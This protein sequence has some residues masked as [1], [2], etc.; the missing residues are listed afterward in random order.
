MSPRL[1]IFPRSRDVGFDLGYIIYTVGKGH[2]VMN[3]QCL[4]WFT[5]VVGPRY[6]FFA[7]RSQTYE[8]RIYNGGQVLQ[9]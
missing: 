1:G 3:I 4:N 6:I 2:S 5:V 9:V 8:K 7:D